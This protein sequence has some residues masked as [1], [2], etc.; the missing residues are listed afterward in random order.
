[1]THGRLFDPKTPPERT[2]MAWER[3][4]FSGMVVGLLMARVGATM[5]PALGAVGVAQVCAAAGLL[6]WSGKHY[7]DLHASL[8]AGRP[9]THPRA[10]GAVGIGAVATTAVATVL[11][12]LAATVGS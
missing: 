10:V 7:R 1:M 2:S 3:T 9:A 5:H 8:H 6:V 4:A 12:V 11:A